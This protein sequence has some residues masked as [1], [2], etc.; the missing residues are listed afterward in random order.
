[1]TN[2]NNNKKTDDKYAEYK[3]FFANL[4]GFTAYKIY[5]LMS[6]VKN[7]QINN[8]VATDIEKNFRGTELGLVTMGIIAGSNKSFIALKNILSEVEEGQ[9]ND[10]K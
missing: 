6:A 7:Q 10:S 5:K 4:D 1:M 8:F 2:N 3:K 9:K